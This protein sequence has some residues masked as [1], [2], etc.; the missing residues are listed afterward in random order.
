MAGEK[1]GSD[2]RARSWTGGTETRMRDSLSS[3]MR[4]S[5]DLHVSPALRELFLSTTFFASESPGTILL[6]KRKGSGARSDQQK[7]TRASSLPFPDFDDR[8]AP[9]LP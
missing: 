8:T 9:D 4:T 3:T 7:L 1:P 2:Q 6:G 5:V